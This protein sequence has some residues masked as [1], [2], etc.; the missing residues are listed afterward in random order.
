RRRHAG[1]A[2]FLRHCPAASAPR[3]GGEVMSEAILVLNP[4]SSSIKFSVFPGRARPS[5]QDL[6]CEGECEGIGHQARFWAKDSAGASLVY[7]ALAD[8][9]THEGALAALMGWL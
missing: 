1:E 8:G 6:V 5:R 2:G 4:G 3:D 9:A 7:E